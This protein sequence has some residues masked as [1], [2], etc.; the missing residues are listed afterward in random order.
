MIFL[1]DGVYVQARLF[2]AVYLPAVGVALAVVVSLLIPF[3]SFPKDHL[4]AFMYLAF[5]PLVYST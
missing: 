1:Y 5:M 2:A 4:V 3:L